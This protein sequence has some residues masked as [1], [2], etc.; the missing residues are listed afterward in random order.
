MLL[1]STVLYTLLTRSPGISPPPGEYASVGS[2]VF[3]NPV[4]KVDHLSDIC[5][6]DSPVRTNRV[7]FCH[8]NNVYRDPYHD[9]YFYVDLGKTI[10][11][12]GVDCVGFICKIDDVSFWGIAEDENTLILK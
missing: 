3:I 9:G 6:M 5:S 8:S 12:D 1:M 2:Y 11:H 10:E 7:W 4:F